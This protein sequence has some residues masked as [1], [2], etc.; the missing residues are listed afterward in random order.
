[1][2]RVQASDSLY[3]RGKPYE[4]RHFNDRMCN[5]FNEQWVLKLVYIL[6]VILLFVLHRNLILLTH[7]EEI[8]TRLFVGPTAFYSNSPY[9]QVNV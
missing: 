1:M 4:T 5:S 7:T 6:Y 2:I 9:H 8:L 3:T